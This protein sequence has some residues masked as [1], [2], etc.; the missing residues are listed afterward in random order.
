MEIFKT[1]GKYLYCQL[2]DLQ[3]F[4][5]GKDFEL[6]NFS[7]GAVTLTKILILKKIKYSGYSI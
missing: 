3:P 4:T 1:F 7:F 5:V 6:E 2:D